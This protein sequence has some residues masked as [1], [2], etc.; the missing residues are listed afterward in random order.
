MAAQMW[1]WTSPILQNIKEAFNLRYNA[2]VPENE[3]NWIDVRDSIYFFGD[4]D[5]LE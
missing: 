4:L 5:I 1:E 3:R 2:L